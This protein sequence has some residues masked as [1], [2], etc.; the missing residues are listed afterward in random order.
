[1]R[2]DV[3]AKEPPDFRYKPKVAAPEGTATLVSGN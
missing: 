2:A 1:M 3:A